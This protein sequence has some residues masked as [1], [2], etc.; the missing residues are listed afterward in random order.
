MKKRRFLWWW[1]WILWIF[2]LNILEIIKFRL[3]VL[4]F[5]IWYMNYIYL[6]HSAQQTK[7]QTPTEPTQSVFCGNIS[8]CNG[9]KK[10]SKDAMSENFYLWSLKGHSH[11]THLN[12][13][14]RN[15][16][17]GPLEYQQ[18]HYL[19]QFQRSL[20][21][22]SLTNPSFSNYPIKDIYKHAFLI[23]DNN[24]TFV[25][26]THS[27]SLAH[28]GRPGVL[29][30]A[31][32]DW[33]SH[34]WL[35]LLRRMA[36]SLRLVSFTEDAPPLGGWGWG[37]VGKPELLTLLDW[38]EVGEAVGFDTLC[39]LGILIPFPEFG[40]RRLLSPWWLT[41]AADEV[42]LPW[43]REHRD[44]GELP[45]SFLSSRSCSLAWPKASVSS[46]RSSHSLR[47]VSWRKVF[48]N[49]KRQGKA[50][51]ALNCTYG[52]WLVI[53]VENWTRIKSLV[54]DCL[55]GYSYHMGQTSRKR[56][57]FV[58]LEGTLRGHLVQPL[59]FAE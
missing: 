10:N 6:T 40:L 36:A 55:C 57:W 37:T 53:E 30:G 48:W 5:S 24:L 27:A 1:W 11:R 23:C 49:E 19:L 47:T 51:L 8:A 31:A 12:M 38:A 20:R 16:E 46:K 54:F 15:R 58:K 59:Q 13:Q 3:K 9:E 17:I 28:W 22:C 39:R 29:R 18:L 7:E 33:I 41:T 44:K 32:L 35:S 26:L 14:Y 50:S 21:K 25:I 42:R 45:L 56:K 52:K 43:W 2:E 34:C 4:P